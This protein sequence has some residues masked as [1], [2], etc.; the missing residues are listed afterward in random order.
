M[1]HEGSLLIHRALELQK[2]ALESAAGG[3]ARVARQA[4]VPVPA[5]LA[6]RRR[7]A[8][9]FAALAAGSLAYLALPRLV[10]RAVSDGQ[11]RVLPERVLLSSL[12]VALG[13]FLLVK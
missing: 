8:P 9:Y 11:G 3:E 2:A 12:A 1:S 13:V 7:L 4:A 6:D 5:G 10:P